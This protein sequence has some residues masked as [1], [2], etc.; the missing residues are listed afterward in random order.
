MKYV[1]GFKK[2]VY[3]L[4]TVLIRQHVRTKSHFWFYSTGW[5]S[6]FHLQIYTNKAQKNIQLSKFIL[7]HFEKLQYLR[8]HCIK[9]V[10][11][12]EKLKCLNIHCIKYARIWVSTDPYSPLSMI[13]SLY[14]IIWIC[15]NPY[16]NAVTMNQANNVCWKFN[17]KLSY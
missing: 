13:L 11:H 4:V 10:A 5:F 17:N 6:I 14:R 2:K 8:I 12:F 9:Y 7:A 3:L 1:K 15:K 16:S